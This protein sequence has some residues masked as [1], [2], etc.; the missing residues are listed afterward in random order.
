MTGVLRLTLISH[1]MTEAMAVARFPGD[2]PLSDVG[3]RQ[4]P[5]PIEGG[6]RQLV[7]PERRAQ[8]TAQLLGLR[9]T[10]EPR[11]ADL[12]Y[13]CWR[14]QTLHEVPPAELQLWLSDP[15]A[16]PHGGE[17]I[18]DLVE[19]V[20]GWMNSLSGATPT[21]AVTHPA[22][23]RAALLVALHAPLEAFWRIDVAPVS[24]TV[25]HLRGQC[26]TLRL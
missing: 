3:R 17:S 1:A 15:A 19:R 6:A 12:D 2:E 5:V 20:A 14:G 10:T 24:R 26:W 23:I 21:S 9:A 22:V 18:G 7:A 25:L 13:G 8:Q 4:V 16:A 11:L